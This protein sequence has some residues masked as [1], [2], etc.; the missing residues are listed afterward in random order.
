[1]ARAYT[2]IFPNRSDNYKATWLTSQFEAYAVDGVV[3]HEGR[4]SPE[5]SNV[6]Y[7]LEVKL[8]RS[9]GLPSIVFEADAYDLRL[10]SIRQIRQQILDFLEQHD[11]SLTD[12]TSAPE[13]I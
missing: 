1:M 12:L 4:T 13:V 8:R 6:Q 11:S 2:G 5:H 7:G 9:T 3:Y 10:F